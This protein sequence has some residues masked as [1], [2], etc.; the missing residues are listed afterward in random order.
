MKSENLATNRVWFDFNNGQW[1]TIIE[2]IE[3]NQQDKEK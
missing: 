2:D 3:Q 1:I